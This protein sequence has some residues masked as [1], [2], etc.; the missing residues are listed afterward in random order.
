MPPLTSVVIYLSQRDGTA[1]LDDTRT[2]EHAHG[3]IWNSVLSAVLSL[4]ASAIQYPW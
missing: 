4:V 3:L 1:A 2:I